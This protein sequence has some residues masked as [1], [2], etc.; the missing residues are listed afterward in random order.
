MTEVKYCEGCT[1]CGGCGQRIR[2][3]HKETMNKKLLQGL[4]YAAKVISDTKVNDFDLHEMIEDYNVYNN[5]QKLRYFGL[6]HHVKDS[7]GRKV[8]GHWLITRNGWAFLRGELSIHKWVKVLDNRIQDRSP[9]LINVR[10]VYRGSDIVVTT[11]EYFDDSGAPVGHRPTM[12]SER[13]TSLV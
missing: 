2:L 5:F 10:E 7:K 6:V 3:A 11:F 12:P 13:Q 4:K 8:R 9:E 1:N